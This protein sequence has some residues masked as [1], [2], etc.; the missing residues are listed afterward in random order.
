MWFCGDTPSGKKKGKGKRGPTNRNSW[1][2]NKR[3]QNAAF[4]LL[5]LGCPLNPGNTFAKQR[6][7]SPFVD[8]AEMDLLGCLMRA[9][10]LAGLTSFCRK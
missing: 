8:L 3:E 10:R 2:E 7:E 5:A 1:E 9:S 6:V 4:M